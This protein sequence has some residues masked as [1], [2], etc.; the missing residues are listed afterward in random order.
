MFERVRAFSPSNLSSRLKLIQLDL[1]ARLPDQALELVREIR[2][3]PDLFTLNRTNHNDLLGF[4]GRAYYLKNEPERAEKLFQRAAK[5]S[6]DDQ[7]LLITATGVYFENR[8]FTNALATLDRLLD[9]SPDSTYAL[10]NK[11]VVYMQ[12]NEFDEAIKNFTHALTVST[13]DYTPRFYRAACEARADQL[14]AAQQDYEILQ[15][16]FPTM[17]QVYYGLGEVS[18]RRK[19]TNAAIANYEKYLA[20]AVTSPTNAAPFP[21][22]VGLVRGRLAELKG[23]KP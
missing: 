20:C 18:Y 7:H 22:E 23:G 16:A 4:E 5:L 3:H 11:G 17:Y 19:D 10:I 1:L 15:R 14:D 6:P 2:N 8:A 21:E 12:L 13:N 9:I